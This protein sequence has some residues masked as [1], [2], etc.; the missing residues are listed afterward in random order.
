MSSEKCPK[1]EESCEPSESEGSCKKLPSGG[2]V[3][4]RQ[5]PALQPLQLV[6]EKWYRFDACKR[7]LWKLTEHWCVVLCN[8]KKASSCSKSSLNGKIVIPKG[9]IVD[10]ASV[11]LP[12]LVSFLTFGILRPTGIL[13]I[14]SIVHDYAYKHGCLRYRNQDGTETCREICRDDAD[15]L[16]REMIWGINRTVLWAYVAWL[17]VLAGRL[18]RVK[19]ANKCIGRKPPRRELVY[20]VLAFLVVLVVLCVPIAALCVLVA[21]LW[22]TGFQWC[23]VILTL[24][25]VPF[26]GNVI[27]GIVSGRS[28]DPQEPNPAQCGCGRDSSA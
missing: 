22:C 7:R 17:A 28:D 24:T 15:W 9:T 12:W 25:G 21:A 2:W 10:G 23:L 19:Y 3:K 6:T 27:T 13:L 20:A 11:P 26:V 8:T 4:F 14:P 5:W 1:P 18:L 16:F